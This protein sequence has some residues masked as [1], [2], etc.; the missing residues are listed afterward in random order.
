MGKVRGSDRGRAVENKAKLEP[1]PLSVH[2]GALTAR[3]WAGR[4]GIERKCFLDGAKGS[5]ANVLRHDAMAG[6]WEGDVGEFGWLR[7]KILMRRG[8]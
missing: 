4:D 8:T 6:C 1:R 3:R 7:L 2:D 5:R